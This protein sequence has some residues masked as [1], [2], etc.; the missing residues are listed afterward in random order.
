MNNK[1]IITASIWILI[2]AIV[3]PIA[4]NYI[5]SGSI[6]AQVTGESKDWLS[7][8][9]SYLGGVFT[10]YI[11]F[12]ILSKTIKHNFT[13]FNIQQKKQDLE[14]LKK[15]L[16][17]QVSMLDFARIGTIALVIN[18]SSQYQLEIQKLDSFREEVTLKFNSYSL[19][20]DNSN[21]QPVK[22]YWTSYQNCVTKL[23]E[24]I[25]KMTQLIAQLPPHLDGNTVQ[26]LESQVA[27]FDAVR[28]NP[29]FAPHFT[30]VEKINE[31]R[32]KLSNNIQ[33]K[34][35]ISSI[36]TLVKD[37]GQHRETFTND[38]FTKAQSW[39]KSEEDKLNEIINS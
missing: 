33:R 26:F 1:N 19:F 24:D 35:L 4:M 13:V 6:G 39:I 3:I 22:D 27:N 38:T 11:S 10:A 21:D 37:L 7:F 34:G 2:A 16:S 32:I 28:Q 18:D 29:T 14:S 30:D 23:F 36:N 25:T 8:F 31:Y 17:E 12:I 20:Y 5:L 15:M 9:G